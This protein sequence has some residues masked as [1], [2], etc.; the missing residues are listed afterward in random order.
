MSLFAQILSYFDAVVSP[1]RLYIVY[2]FDRSKKCITFHIL[3]PIYL[4]DIYLLIYIYLYIY[5]YL[6]YIFA[7]VVYIHINIYI[8]ANLLY[9]IEFIVYIYCLDGSIVD[10]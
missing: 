5:A 7:F 6:L 4:V 8:C 3:I 10:I 1:L 9:I 2:L